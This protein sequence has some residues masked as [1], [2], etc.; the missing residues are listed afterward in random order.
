MKLHLIQPRELYGPPERQEELSVAWCLND[1]IFDLVTV[2]DGRPSFTQMF[3]LCRP[4]TIN[5]IANSDIHMDHTL[6][7]NAHRLDEREVW[8]LSRYE[9]M[10]TTLLP[11][12]RSDSQDAWVV[13]GD[14]HA[15]D[16]PFAMGVPGC[17]NALAHILTAAGYLVTNPCQTVR[18]IHLHRSAY[19]TYGEG[20]GKPK[21]YRIPPPYAWIFPSSL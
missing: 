14:G 5:V 11:Y 15:I 10:G 20:R 8:A 2:P 3:A 9:D 1:A 6:R 17:D 19:R 4:D 12:H 21:E 13:L 18:A 7:D 16:A